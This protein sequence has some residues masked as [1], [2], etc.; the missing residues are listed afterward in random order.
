MTDDEWRKWTREHHARYEVR[1]LVA[2]QRDQQ[3]QIAW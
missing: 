3:V 2:I 1:P